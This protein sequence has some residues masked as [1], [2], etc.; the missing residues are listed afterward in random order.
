MTY[1]ENLFY[2]ASP[3]IHRRA[4]ELRK[5]MTPAEKKLWDI[6]KGKSLSGFKFRRQHPIKKF[7]V[8]FYCHELKLVIEVDG[9]IHNQKDQAE[10]DLGRTFELEELGLKVIRFRNEEV[11]DLTEEV[12]DR[13]SGFLA[14]PRPSPRGEGA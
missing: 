5:Q 14:P 12:L 6:L 2:G 11:F 13:I 4:R 8:D 10:Y 1:S 3:E 7:I 9:S